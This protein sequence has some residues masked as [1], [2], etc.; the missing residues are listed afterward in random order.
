MIPNIWEN[1]KNGNQTTN[2][3]GIEPKNH[4]DDSESIRNTHHPSAV[5]VD[6]KCCSGAP[7]FRKT[8]VFSLLD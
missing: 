8:Q 1:K 7:C 4:G 3:I 2:Q 6:A 5:N